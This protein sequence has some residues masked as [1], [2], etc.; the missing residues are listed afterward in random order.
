M[1]RLILLLLSLLS[2][3]AF[4]TTSLQAGGKAKPRPTPAHTTIVS[5][6]GNSI[7]VQEAKVTKT[8]TVTKETEIDY[9]GQ[10]ATLSQLQPGMRVEVTSGMTEGVASRINASEAPA[11]KK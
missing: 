3:T 10:R 2:F 9:N 7:T 4:T 6:N 1:K 5:V 11:P 8:F